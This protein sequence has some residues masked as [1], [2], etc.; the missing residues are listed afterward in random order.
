MKPTQWLFN[1]NGQSSMHVCTT[2]YV[3]TKEWKVVDFSP[4]Q[5]SQTYNGW[6]TEEIVTFLHE[7]AACAKFIYSAKERKKNETFTW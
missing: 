6:H 7:S 2:V 5:A 1:T 3:C 4:V